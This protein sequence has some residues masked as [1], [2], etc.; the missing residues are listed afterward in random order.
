M[1]GDG[2]RPGTTRGVEMI[3]RTQ[4][5]DGNEDGSGDKN[6]NEYGETSGGG[7]SE[8]CHTRNEAE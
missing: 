3:Q 2:D 4:Y 7:S 1:D 5:G 8:T 6:G